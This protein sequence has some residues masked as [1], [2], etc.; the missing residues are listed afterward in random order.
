MVIVEVVKDIKNISPRKAVYYIIWLTYN[1]S[2]MTLISGQ[3][4]RKHNGENM[5]DSYDMNKKKKEKE[6][7]Y[8]IEYW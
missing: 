6:E 3:A 7:N 2:A 8:M 4:Q 5:M 1:W